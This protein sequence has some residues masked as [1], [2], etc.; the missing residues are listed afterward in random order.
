MIED[1]GGGV[2]AIS[3]VLSGDKSAGKVV[4]GM[5]GAGGGSKDLDTCSGLGSDSN[6][7]SSFIADRT[8]EGGH[9]DSVDT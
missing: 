2:D 6:S 7:G 8:R 5:L 1:K 4:N 3:E 9:S